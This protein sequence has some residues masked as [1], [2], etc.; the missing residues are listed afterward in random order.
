MSNPTLREWLKRETRVAHHQVDQ[1]PALK[2]LLSRELT[3]AKY[4]TALSALYA[5]IASLEQ[6]LSS[7]LQAHA[8]DYRLMQREPLLKADIQRL[9]KRVASVP[10]A[11][12][13]TSPANTVGM[14]YVLEGSRLGGAM[15]ARHVESVLGRQVPL[16]FLTAHP[17]TGEQWAAFWHF[18]EYHCPLSTWPAV[19]AGAQQ[20]FERFTL[21]LAAFAG[22]N[23]VPIE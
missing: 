4:A 7:G 15:I 21:D 23:P 2:P 22:P 5:P 1:H 19:L 12:L 16:Q 8:M 14:L 6:A 3:V 9:G 18:A 20:A 13:P 11:A 10:F 17:L